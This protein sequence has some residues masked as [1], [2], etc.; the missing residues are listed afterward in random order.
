MK[1]QKFTFIDL[2]SGAG[3]FSIGFTKVGFN[4][5][6]CVDFNPNVAATHKENF[7]QIPFLEANLSDKEI[8]N[9][10]INK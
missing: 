9:K 3:G 2:F 6:L 8:Q 5:L 4:P 1:N 7:S 10:I